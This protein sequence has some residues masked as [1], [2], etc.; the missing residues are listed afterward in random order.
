VR[1]GR[2]SRELHRRHRGGGRATAQFRLRHQAGDGSG[3]LAGLLLRRLGSAFVERF[4]RH[5]GGSDA[6][7]VWKLA[8]TGQSLVF[9]PEGTFDST[10]QVGKFLGGAFATAQRASMPVVAVAV[11]GTR[12]VLPA[13][14]LMVRRKPI[15]FEVL[16]VMAPD[17]AASG[18]AK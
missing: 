18:A 14:T 17:G 8:A 15:R 16:G 7:R 3:A 6:R 13:G 11:H 12:K 10:P 1:G 4:D 9:F 5:K 2:Q